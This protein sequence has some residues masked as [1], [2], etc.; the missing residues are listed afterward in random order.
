MGLRKE[1]GGETDGRLTLGK[2][3]EAVL[4]VTP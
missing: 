1:S 4:G 2:G 3:D